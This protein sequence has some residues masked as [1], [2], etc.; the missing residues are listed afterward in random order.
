VTAHDDEEEERRRQEAERKKMRL[1]D[2]VYDAP[3][4]T[5]ITG[6]ISDQH[7][8]RTGRVIPML[9]RMTLRT[10]AILKALKERDQI[11]S[12]PVFLEILLEAY[13]EKY[14]E[15]PITIPSDEELVEMFERERDERDK[16]K[17]HGK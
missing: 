8:R 9:V 6:R 5:T 11:P 17:R 4:K 3:I 1:V 15:P 16:V 10:E 14:R 7:K 2:R 12:D 13:L